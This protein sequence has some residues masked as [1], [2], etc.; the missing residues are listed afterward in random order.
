MS[1]YG[2][3]TKKCADKRIIQLLKL[4]TSSYKPQP[5]IQF[6]LFFFIQKILIDGGVIQ[7][8]NNEG[9]NGVIHVIDKVLLPPTLAIGQYL[10]EKMNMR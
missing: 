7:N 6:F 3:C 8:G 4:E 10:Q 1:K 2:F 9:R 5:R